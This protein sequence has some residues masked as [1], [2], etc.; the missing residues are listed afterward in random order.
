MWE[1]RASETRGNGL[2]PCEAK[3]GAVRGEEV[4]AERHQ[5]VTGSF[6]GSAA[7][8]GSRLRQRGA[9]DAPGGMCSPSSGEGWSEGKRVTGRDPG[10]WESVTF[11]G[12]ETPGRPR[13]VSERVAM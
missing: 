5:K 12:E 9:K 7:T 6:R 11:K 1:P 8:A 2:K 3:R 10:S 13:L 4:L